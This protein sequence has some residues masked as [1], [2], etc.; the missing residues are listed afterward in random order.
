MASLVPAIVAM[1]GWANW[2]PPAWLDRVLPAV[3]AA[4]AEPVWAWAPAG[5]GRPLSGHATPVDD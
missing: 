1:F 5:A 3:T 4:A 2:W